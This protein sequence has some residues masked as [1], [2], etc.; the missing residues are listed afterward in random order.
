MGKYNGAFG[1]PSAATEEELYLDSTCD[2]NDP[3]HNSPSSA[4]IVVPGGIAET[5]IT[6]SKAKAKTE[7]GI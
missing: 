4:L 1:D 5:L 7:L 2:E 6:D 3:T